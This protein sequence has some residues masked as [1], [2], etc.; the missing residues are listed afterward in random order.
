V[1][2]VAVGNAFLK[3]PMQPWLS[4]YERDASN[5]FVEADFTR[6]WKA[7]TILLIATTTVLSIIMFIH[8]ARVLPPNLSLR[9][10]IQNY[11]AHP[12]ITGDVHMRF[13]S[14]VMWTLLGLSVVVSVTI[15]PVLWEQAPSCSSFLQSV[16]MSSSVKGGDK[17]ATC[18]V[19]GTVFTVL[20]GAATFRLLSKFSRSHQLDETSLAERIEPQQPHWILQSFRRVPGSA[21][22]LRLM[23]IVTC[24]GMAICLLNVPAAIDIIL[25]SM[26]RNS[27]FPDRLMQVSKVMAP[28]IAALADTFVI[29]AVSVIAARAMMARN[30]VQHQSIVLALTLFGRTVFT[31]LV[32]VIVVVAIDNACAQNWKYLWQPCYEHAFDISIY[33]PGVSRAY[34]VLTTSELCTPSLVWSGCA[35]AVVEVTTNIQ[36]RKMLVQIFALP[37]WVLVK[38]VWI[39]YHSAE[40][41]SQHHK[42]VLV[43][44]GAGIVGAVRVVMRLPERAARMCERHGSDGGGSEKQSSVRDSSTTQLSVVVISMFEVAVVYGYMSPGIVSLAAISVCIHYWT[45]CIILTSNRMVEYPIRSSQAEMRQPM[46]DNNNCSNSLSETQPPLLSPA[47]STTRL[48]SPTPLPVTPLPSE[49]QTTTGA[50]FDTP[51]SSP[52]IP[53]SYLVVGVVFECVFAVCFATNNVQAEHAWLLESV[54]AV[55]IGVIVG[56]FIIV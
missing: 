26:P 42:G 29:P 21:T 22:P 1:S 7:V 28:V 14:S 39:W 46:L 45:F 31:Q 19:L 38:H 50:P 13:A 20:V 43:K 47:M 24:W 53:V 12:A 16:S 49:N 23:L 52:N 34:P 3:D 27:V 44:I 32:P 35:V 2:F 4:E 33:L 54:C 15:V 40:Y 11:F 10:L 55:T 41:E 48:A 17:R 37:T 25:V 5:L 51:V 6:E 30:E 18:V 8:F 56:N 36:I 9:F